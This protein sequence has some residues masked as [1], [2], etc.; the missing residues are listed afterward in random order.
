[1]LNTMVSGL[2]DNVAKLLVRFMFENLGT[3]AQEAEDMDDIE[4]SQDLHNLAEKFPNNTTTPDDWVE[5]L[6]QLSRC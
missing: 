4:L 5:A 1:M 6:Q 3:L 2:N